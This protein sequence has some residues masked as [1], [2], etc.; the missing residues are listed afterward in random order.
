M[1]FQFIKRQKQLKH[2][3][4]FMAT[5]KN[6]AQENEKFLYI[7]TVIQKMHIFRDNSNLIN[8]FNLTL[9]I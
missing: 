1:I 5:V 4:T 6:S 3:N 8:N 9:E 2:L 7:K